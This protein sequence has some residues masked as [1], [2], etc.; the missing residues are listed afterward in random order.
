MQPNVTSILSTAYIISSEL[1]FLHSIG[2]LNSM[3]TKYVVYFIFFNQFVY[4][5]ITKLTQIDSVCIK[6]GKILSDCSVH[7]LCETLWEKMVLFLK[8][9]NS[10]MRV[11][12]IC[13]N[14]C[15]IMM[16]IACVLP[17][18]HSIPNT[19]WLIHAITRFWVK[20]FDYVRWTAL[21]VCVFVETVICGEYTPFIRRLPKF[22]TCTN[23]ST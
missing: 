12:T 21:C 17:V 19:D 5:F 16:Y 22:T 14:T 11:F 9:L 4:T 20:G 2:N 10:I 6:F 15:T 8:S 23:A 18:Y 1:T 13:T 3:A 7:E